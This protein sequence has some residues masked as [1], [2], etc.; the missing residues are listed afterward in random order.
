[1][2]AH[3]EVRG[4]PGGVSYLFRPHLFWDGTQVF[5]TDGKFLFQHVTSREFPSYL[6]LATIYFTKH[7]KA[8]KN[9]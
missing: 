2:C 6:P 1:M 4:Q 7:Y 3:V 5:R 8:C 9:I